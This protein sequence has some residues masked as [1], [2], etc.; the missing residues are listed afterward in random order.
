V[1]EVEQAYLKAREL[2][3]QVHDDHQ[4]FRA[5]IGLTRCYSVRSQYH[6]G[7]ELLDLLL[8]VAQRT[9]APPHRGTYDADKP[10]AVCRSVHRSAQ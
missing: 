1:P 10:H 4:L 9:Q 7:A 8:Q 5:L 2:C 6:Q 3:E